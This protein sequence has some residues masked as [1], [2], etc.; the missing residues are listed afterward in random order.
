[1]Q[2][3]NFQQ[4]L[5]IVLALIVALDSGSRLFTTQAP[6]TQTPVA[7]VQNKK[8]IQCAKAP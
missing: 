5:A 1:M 6:R 3:F 2:F 7:P 4:A 8:P